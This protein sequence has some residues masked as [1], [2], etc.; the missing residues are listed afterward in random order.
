MYKIS[1]LQIYIIILIAISMQIGPLNYLKIFGMKPDVVLIS[2]VFF[3]L[4]L[5]PGAGLEAG[6]AAGLLKDIFTLDFFWINTFIMALAGLCV[7]MASDKFF[8][9]SKKAV[10]TVV[11]F[12]TIL[13]MSA[14]YFLVYIFSKNFAL[15]YFSYFLSSVMPACIYTG[16]V[17]IPLYIAFVNIY[18]LK[19]A[20][21]YI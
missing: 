2:V 3:G 20:D 4:L 9:E 10:F 17:S 7:G 19:E 11:L 6:I 16:L 18:N 12:T 8:K 14:H 1:R 21:D 5:G 15:N 13:S